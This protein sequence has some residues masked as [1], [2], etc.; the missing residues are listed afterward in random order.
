MDRVAMPR[1]G[2]TNTRVASPRDTLR[3]G[4]QTTAGSGQAPSFER[5]DAEAAPRPV[6]GSVPYAWVAVVEA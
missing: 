2:V 1:F 3:S 4:L 6:L 5:E